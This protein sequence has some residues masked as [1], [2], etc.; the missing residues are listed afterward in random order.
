MRASRHRRP[1]LAPGGRRVLPV[2]SHRYALRPAYNPGRGFIDLGQC[3][4]FGTLRRWSLR[5]RHHRRG[6]FAVAVFVDSRQ[7]KQQPAKGRA[8]FGIEVS[9]V[10]FRWLESRNLGSGCLLSTSVVNGGG[11]RDRIIAEYNNFINFRRGI[12]I[13]A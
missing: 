9:Y 12:H 10:S 8:V 1:G 5:T 3:R 13:R 7:L 6:P 11:T 2:R 4:D